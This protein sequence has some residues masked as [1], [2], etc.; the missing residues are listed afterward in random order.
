[1]ARPVRNTA[2]AFLLANLFVSS[3][4]AGTLTVTIRD[5]R[6][7]SPMQGAF[8]MV[9][10]AKNVP[11][12]GNTALTGA[13]GTVTFNNAALQRTE[14][15]T[16]GKQDFAYY[17][18]LNNGLGALTL[19]L[20]PALAESVVYGEK[21]RVTGAVNSI[22]TR[23][24]DDS[25][26]VALVMPALPLDQLLLGGKVLYEVPPDVA[27]L[28]GTLVPMPGNVY[29]PLQ[30]EYFFLQFKKLNYK[31]DFPAQTRQ[32]IYAICAR[33]PIDILLTP[34]P[35]FEL[36]NY[37]KVREIGVERNKA[38]GS[39][40]NLAINAD[41]NL[42]HKLTFRF[43]GVANGN[44][45]TGL[46]LGSIPDQQQQET[47]IG[48]DSKFKLVDLGNTLLL[49]STNPTGDIN[50]VANLGVGVYGDSS[51]FR[52][53]LSG[54][55]DRSAVTLPATR[56]FRD[57]YDPPTVIQNGK[58][59]AWNDVQTP[60]T[61]PDPTWS[62][63]EI[64]LVPLDPLDESFVPHLCWRVVVAAGENG[65]TLPVLPPDAPGPAGGIVYA[66]ETPEEDQLVWSLFVANPTGDLSQVLVRPTAGVTHFSQRQIPFVQTPAAADL[67]GE[68]GRACV[69]VVPN[70]ASSTVRIEI[71]DGVGMAEVAVHDA[72]GRVVRRLVATDGIAV[73]N[74]TDDRGRRL[75]AGIYL[76]RLPGADGLCKLN[77]M[78]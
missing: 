45:V 25:L 64:R 61:E 1:M 59:I 28:A 7:G 8:V 39:G 5:A 2:L 69:Q 63:T 31:I 12:V 48:Y 10:T 78:P 18:A 47:I 11:F 77:W 68:G 27:D 55:I 73:W 44:Q 13:S 20:S 74:G 33:L 65:F 67:S 75:P 16:A 58:G 36:L 76:V 34:P 70:P 22:A 21:A 9:G 4:V 17:T 19:D 49:A 40:I 6:S 38:V 71:L 14:M 15:V 29:L 24:N 42:P 72:T 53:Y 43:E 32:S 50:D 3:G 62:V 26:D 41:I 30:T 51:A 23:D 57:F 52:T 60:G 66:N 37:A 56:T 35:Q 54:R 46:S